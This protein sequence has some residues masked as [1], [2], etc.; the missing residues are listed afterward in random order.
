MSN[1]WWIRVRLLGWSLILAW[2]I[3]YLLN[4]GFHIVDRSVLDV[5]NGVLGALGTFLVLFGYY[6]LTRDDQ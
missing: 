2:F 4:L 5:A 3:L 6:M 1:R